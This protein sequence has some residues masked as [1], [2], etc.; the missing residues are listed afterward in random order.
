MKKLSLTVVASHTASNHRDL[1]WNPQLA[2]SG[3]VTLS[4]SVKL[5]ETPF[6]HV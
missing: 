3:C 6:P 1:D 2:F 4:K 5:S